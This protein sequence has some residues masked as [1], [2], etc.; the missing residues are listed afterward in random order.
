MI[1]YPHRN[2][3]NCCSQS[4]SILISKYGLT[5]KSMMCYLNFTASKF[6]STYV[7]MNYVILVFIHLCIIMRVCFSL[8]KEKM[9]NIK[10]NSS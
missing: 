5:Y 1:D 2:F 3:D 6:A 10:Y 4:I 8:H 7:F 9:T